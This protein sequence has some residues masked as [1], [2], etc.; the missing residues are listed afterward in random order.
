VDGAPEPEQPSAPAAAF[1]V[2][3]RIPGAKL[4]GGSGLVERHRREKVR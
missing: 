2:E 3:R 4:T 1:A